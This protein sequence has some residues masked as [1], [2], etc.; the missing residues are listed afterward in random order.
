MTCTVFVCLALTLTHTSVRAETLIEALSSA[1]RYSPR[2]DAER[3]R[4]RAS[5][6]EVARAMSGYRPT[7]TGSA[8]INYQKTTVGPPSNTTVT[9]PRGYQVDFTQPVFT[10]FRTFNAVN[11]SEATVRAARETLR[12]TEQAVLLDAVTAFM[13][14]L[15]DQAIVRIN[16]RNVRV[17]TNELDATQQRFS[18]GE[19][20]KTDVAQARARRAGAVSSLDLARANLKTSR[21]NFKQVIGHPPNRLVAPSNYSRG[22]PGSIGEAISV[23]RQENPNVVIALYQE[24]AAG[25]AV[26]RIRGELLPSIQLEASHADRFGQGGGTG[27]GFGFNETETTTVTGRLTVPFYQGGE[28]H[29][30][31]RQAKHTHVSFIQEIEQARVTAEAAVV[32]AWSQ[33]S[34]ARAQLESDRVQVESNRIALAGVREEERVGQRDLLDV[35]NAEQEFL[36]SQVQLETTKRN[37]VVN[38]YALLQAIGRLDVLTLGA[39]NQVYDPEAHYYEVRRKWWGVSITHADGRHED[40]QIEPSEDWDHSVK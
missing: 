22:I 34:A 24:Q 17:L 2:I 38:S 4:L 36:N 39:A 30:R 14:V 28:V 1:Y 35:L 8:D 3:A 13:D 21:A 25:Y 31:V 18:V 6:E 23:A 7:L 27:G 11:E 37:L 16:E 12:N 29:A 10:G 26:N 20:T 19:V 15:R 5:D 9:H 32:G 33:L 40:L